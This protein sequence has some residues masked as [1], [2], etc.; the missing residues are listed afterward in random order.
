MK[1]CAFEA[2]LHSPFFLIAGTCVVESEQLA[3][4][5]AGQLKEICEMSLAREREDRYSTVEAFRQDLV[6]FL[7]HR[8]SIQIA[9]Q[10]DSE[11]FALSHGSEKDGSTQDRYRC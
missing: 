3:I 2:G 11:M 1:L 5:T 7:E 10:A 9:Q 4:D 6:V 8:E